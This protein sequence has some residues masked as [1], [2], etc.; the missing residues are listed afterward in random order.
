MDFDV[1]ALPDREHAEGVVMPRQHLL[2]AFDH[3]GGA[4]LR[5]APRRTIHLQD[6]VPTPSPS[7]E[8]VH[9]RQ[10]AEVVDVEVRDEDLVE[11]VQREARGDVIRD[12]PF[13]EVENEVLTVAELDQD[14]G[15]HLTR[16]DERCSYP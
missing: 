6:P 12:R 4:E 10:R 9:V 7:A 11:L 3:R 2:H 8:F 15:V 16:T 14:R 5:R 1:V 13:A